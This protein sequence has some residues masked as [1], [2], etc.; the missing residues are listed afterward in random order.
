MKKVFSSHASLAH[1]WANQ[2]HEIGKA[3]AMFFDGP[4][5]YSYGYHYEIARFIQAPNGEKVCFI[6]SNKQKQIN[7]KQLIIIASIF[8]GIVLFNLSAWNII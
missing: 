2:T 4:V 7:M 5:I 3:S 8:A 1:A 6:N